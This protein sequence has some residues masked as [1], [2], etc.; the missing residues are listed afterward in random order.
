MD[1]KEQYPKYLTY[2][3]RHNLPPSVL[4]QEYP[5]PTLGEKE[6][7]YPVNK[8][9]LPH[10][11]SEKELQLFGA[12]Q[13]CS[14][15]SDTIEVEHGLVIP[16][17]AELRRIPFKI[18]DEP[19]QDLFKTA[20]DEGFHAEQSLAFLTQLENH[21]GVHTFSESLPPLFIRRL[22]QQRSL[23]TNPVHKQLITILNGVVTETRIS[24]ELGMFAKNE[25][26][27]DSIRRICL[28]HAQDEVIHSSQ[29]QALGHWLWDDFNE[30]TKELSSSF[31]INSTIARSLP[32]IDNII[33]SFSNA[34]G[35]AMEDAT[36]LVL[37]AYNEDLLIDLMTHDINHTLKYLHKLG[38]ENYLSID[39]A[40][41]KEREKLHLE[42]EKRRK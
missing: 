25:E 30:E 18:P 32:D 15:L 14:F 4:T 26:L 39:M 16:A 27:S 11:S 37:K 34:T 36:K 23:L 7:Y 6:I 19:K 28:T 3:H 22:K 38:V 17:I 21:F 13:F 20:T 42:F 12:S 35:R 8:I 41:E 29:F 10:F 1:S 31:F 24:H 5:L 9:L 33:I 40:I 2:E